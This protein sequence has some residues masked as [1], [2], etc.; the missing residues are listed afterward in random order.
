MSLK[1]PDGLVV[2]VSGLRGRVGDPLTPELVCGLAA[3][4]GAFVGRSAGA[5]VARGGEI[6]KKTYETRPMTQS[7]LRTRELKFLK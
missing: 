4:F 7:F 2:S 5:G 1:I 6:L 3:A